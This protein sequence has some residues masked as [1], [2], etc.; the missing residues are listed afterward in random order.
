MKPADGARVVLDTGDWL[1]WVP[2]ASGWPYGLLLAPRDHT[3]GLPELTSVARDSLATV[4][5]DV[6]GRY[7]RL[8]ARAFPYMLWIHQQP[9]DAHS[10]LHVHVATPLRAAHTVRFVAGGEL[11]SGT[12]FNPIVPEAAAAA[13]RDA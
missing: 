10:H 8:F 7:D 13:L 9:G 11:G 12:Y 3:A 1:A 5:A 6:L 2:Y 4:L